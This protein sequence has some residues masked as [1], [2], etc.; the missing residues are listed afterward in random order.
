MTAFVAEHYAQNLSIE[1]IAQSA[2]LHPNYAMNLFKAEFGISLGEFLM[3]TRISHAQRLLATT[4]RGV[5]DIAYQCGFGSPSR[6]HAA[7]KR[8]CGTTPGGYK[9][10]LHH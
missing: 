8:I 9:K 6:F 4:D 1:T 2:N 7:F 3:R 5:L 10:S